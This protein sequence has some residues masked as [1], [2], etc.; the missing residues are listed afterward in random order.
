MKRSAAKQGGGGG[1]K[2]AKGDGEIVIAAADPAKMVLPPSVAEF[3][4]H[5]CYCTHVG[6]V[7]VR[8][9]Q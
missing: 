4:K 1:K 3:G 8:P 6:G 9:T 7:R 5:C 2:A